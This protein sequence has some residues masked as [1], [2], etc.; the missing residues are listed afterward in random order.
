M[1]IKEIV[2]EKR[3]IL[4]NEREKTQNLSNKAG[5]LKSVFQEVLGREYENYT[6]TDEINHIIYFIY[7]TF[8]IRKFKFEKT[9][10]SADISLHEDWY[11]KLLKQ[12]QYKFYDLLIEKYDPIFPEGLLTSKE[13][14][15]IQS[16]NDSVED[17]KKFEDEI[18]DDLITL[19]LSSHQMKYY[20]DYNVD[21]FKFKIDKIE[22]QRATPDLEKLD[23]D[24]NQAELEMESEIGQ[25]IETIYSF[26]SDEL[27]LILD[28]GLL[29]YYIYDILQDHIPDSREEMMPLVKESVRNTR[30]DK[31]SVTEQKIVELITDLI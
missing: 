22:F 6:E 15:L 20:F 24:K 10:N 14:D 13:I 8:G 11:F 23:S 2:E 27:E 1:S 3:E 21:N 4:E 31:Y 18:A 19:L 7:H 28:P 17:A 26:S 12:E 30:P 25:D 16:R 29:S 5:I 9:Y